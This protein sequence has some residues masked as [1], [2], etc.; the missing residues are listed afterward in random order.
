MLRYNMLR[1]LPLTRYRNNRVFRTKV[2]K[3]Y[4]K[5]DRYIMIPKKS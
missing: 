1:K 3:T 2:S 4:N 5:E